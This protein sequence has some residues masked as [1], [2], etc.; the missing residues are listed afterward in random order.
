MKGCSPSLL[1]TLRVG[2]RLFSFRAVCCGD[3]TGKKAPIVF[4]PN[5]DKEREKG[6]K[7]NARKTL[8]ITVKETI[9]HTKLQK[10]ASGR[11]SISVL[12]VTYAGCPNDP[13]NLREGQNV[14]AQSSRN[15]WNGQFKLT[16]SD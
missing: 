4:V 3:E 8:P 5:I 15:F 14:S 12:I 9:L 16:V 1:S 10:P 2:V 6:I 13:R 7:Q 11:L